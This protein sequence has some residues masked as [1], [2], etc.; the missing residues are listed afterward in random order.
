MSSPKRE[1]SHSPSGVPTYVPDG[2]LAALYGSARAFVFLSEYEGLGLT[3]L[4]ALSVGVPPVLLDTPVAR[5]SCGAAAVY[6]RT[7]DVDAIAERSQRLQCVARSAGIST[8]ANVQLA[9]GRICGGR[10]SGVHAWSDGMERGLMHRRDQPGANEA[11]GR[12]AHG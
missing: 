7:G 11:A 3:P 5:E 4:E 1:I 12:V 9:G 2:E 10:C 8:R 6:A